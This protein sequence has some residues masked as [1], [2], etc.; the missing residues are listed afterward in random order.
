M[1][2]YAVGLVLACFVAA[3]IGVGLRSEPAIAQDPTEDRLS[4]LETR[5]ADLET[6]LSVLEGD[7]VP[8]AQPSPG[9]GEGTVVLSGVG[10]VVTE[11]FWLDAGRYEVTVTYESGCCII[12]RPYGPSGGE[13]RSIFNEISS[14]VG[15]QAA[16][17]YQA[18]DSGNYFLE[19]SNNNGPWTLT[20]KKR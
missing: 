5:V 20:F 17:I 4:A 8:T 7:A 2:A 12:V 16:T 19:V 3:W 10:S 11:D 14:N 1:R 6:R 9:S 18:S 13:G 15:G